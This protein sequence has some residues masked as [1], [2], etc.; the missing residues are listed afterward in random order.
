[1]RPHIRRRIEETVEAAGHSGAQA[2][3]L[4]AM[5]YASIE[6]FLPTRV[7]WGSASWVR[8]YNH[9]DRYLH[10]HDSVQSARQRLDDIA[11]T[12]SLH[13]SKDGAGILVR[14]GL[15][16]RYRGDWVGVVEP[17]PLESATATDLA[18]A[19]QQLLGGDPTAAA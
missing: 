7:Q 3:Q 9:T 2:Q 17:N 4:A 16:R 13:R 8:V 10:V 18:S 14:S 19:V 11:S 6:E 15:L 12:E 5:V 1:M